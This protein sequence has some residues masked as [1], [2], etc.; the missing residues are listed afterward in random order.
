MAPAPI[1]HPQRPSATPQTLIR[2]HGHHDQ[3]N[4]RAR[5]QKLRTPFGARDRGSRETRRHP[6]LTLRLDQDRG[7]LLARR[8]ERV[9]AGPIAVRVGRQGAAGFSEETL[10]MIVF[11]LD[12]HPRSLLFKSE[13]RSVAPFLHVAS[14]RRSRRPWARVEGVEGRPLAV[15]SCGG[16]R[17]FTA[18]SVAIQECRD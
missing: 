14:R 17:P 13:Q 18:C 7:R 2:A 6:C 16:H 11:K 1:A 12:C 10:G 15:R 8:P 9:R 4:R 3:S 5:V